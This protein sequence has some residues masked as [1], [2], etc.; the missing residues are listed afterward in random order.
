MWRIQSYNT[1]LH[2]KYLNIGNASMSCD[3]EEGPVHPFRC[4]PTCQCSTPMYTPRP[5]R[6]DIVEQRLADANWRLRE[7]AILALGAVAEGCSGG[8]AQYVPQL[9]GAQSE[10]RPMPPRAAGPLGISLDVAH[11]EQGNLVAVG[12]WRF[13]AVAR[14]VAL[15]RC[16]AAC[17]A[18]LCALRL[19]L[20]RVG[21][22]GLRRSARAAAH[23]T[24]SCS[25]SRRC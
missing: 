14:S 15:L 7:S 5:G 10:A 17:G 9:I 20:P 6:T 18:P 13:A 1:E 16:N 2:K 22:L 11:G 12:R 23:R 24:R 21:P 4:A 3:R 25:R 19:R 8:L